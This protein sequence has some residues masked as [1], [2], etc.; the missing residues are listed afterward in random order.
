MVAGLGPL[1]R[2]AVY[3]AALYLGHERLA[4][5]NMVDAKA[6]I[7]L[8]AQH[9]VV[10]PRIAFL[11]LVEQA[12]AVDQAQVEQGLEVLALF[13]GVVNG[14]AQAFGVEAVAVLRRN[15]EVAQQHQA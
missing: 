4:H 10:P 3:D 9:A 14:F 2:H 8:V 15:V 13:S 5:E 11:G 12:E 1:A 6:A 7:L